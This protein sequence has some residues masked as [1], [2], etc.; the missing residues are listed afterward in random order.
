MKR[1]VLIAVG[2]ALAA[3][4]LAYAAPGP[5]G[6]V[7]P[8]LANKP[9]AMPPGQAKKMWRRGERLPTSY[10]VDQRYILASPQR[11]RLP[12]PPRGYRWVGV[13]GSAYLVQTETGLIREVIATLLQ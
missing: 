12:P 11:Y 5:P 8:G 9:Y 10:V 6:G 2:L 1:S 7:P 13:D 3:G 4:P